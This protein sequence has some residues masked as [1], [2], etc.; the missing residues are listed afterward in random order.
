MNNLKLILDTVRNSYPSAIIAGGAPRDV[1]YGRPVKDYDILI[2]GC[3][4]GDSLVIG[5]TLFTSCSNSYPST[6]MKVYK[7][8]MFG[9]AIDLV[10]YDAPVKEVEIVDAFSD[11]LSKVYFDGTIVVSDESHS[12]Y[13][14]KFNTFK[15]NTILDQ[16]S[17]THNTARRERLAVK[18]PEI[19]MAVMNDD[20]EYYGF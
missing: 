3:F 12:A 2:A 4:E 7:G 14:R 8:V 15:Y 19:L 18:Y 10:F 6:I 16:R 20:G 9:L 5:T 13:K 1:Y 17:R 11:A